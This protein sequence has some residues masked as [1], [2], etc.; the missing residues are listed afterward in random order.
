[1]KK[2]ISVLL[3]AVILLCL[4]SCDSANQGNNKVPIATQEARWKVGDIV[5]FG[6]YPQTRTGNDN[7]PIEWLVLAWDGDKALIISKYSLD[8]VQYNTKNSDV[9]WET[10]SLRRWLNNDFYNKAF[11]TIEKQNIVSSKVTAD[12]NPEYSTNPGKDTT[13]RVFLLSISEVGKYFSGNKNGMCAPTDYA[14]KK[15]S[16]HISEEYKVA[17]RSCGWWWLR[18]P[19]NSNSNAAYV[20]YDGS[21]SNYGR[22]VNTSYARV[23][24]CMWVRK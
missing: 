19:G 24:P 21:V 6:S 3:M 8:C 5:T 22:Y 18:S 20:Y 11:S 23:R 4:C 7:T 1:M 9:T 12:K 17:G 16:E 15:N 13:D 10:C 14:I 2:V